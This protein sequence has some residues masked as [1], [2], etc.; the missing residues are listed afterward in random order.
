MFNA[1]YFTYDDIS[2]KDYGLRIADFD[3]S[4]VRETEAFSPTLSLL[5]APGQVR[6]FYG[7]VE[8]DSAPTCEFSVVTEEALPGAAR[9]VIM[10]WLVGR[11][12]FRPLRF[13]D[14]DNAEF[15][16]YCIFTGVKTIWVNGRCHGFR[17]T[18]QFDSQFARGPE[19][20]IEVGAGTHIVELYNRSDV[21]SYVYPMV[22]FLGGSVD[23]VNL[24]DDASRHFTFEGVDPNT[25]VTVDNE[26]RHISG[27][28]GA[29]LENFTSKNWLRLRRYKNRLQIT[30]QGPVVITCPYYAMVGY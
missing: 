21:D 25:T 3:D 28:G 19:T 12:Q 30:A 24:T 5:K 29:L 16:Y 26:L 7:K 4:N 27:G 1:T 8:Y 23:I 20:K 22:S 18:A 13:L 15:E 9:S 14:G 2:S 17:L 11:N 6:F 10:S